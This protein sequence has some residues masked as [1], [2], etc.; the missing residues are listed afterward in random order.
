LALADEEGDRILTLLVSESSRRRFRF[1]GE[2]VERL[3]DGRHFRTLPDP[4]CLTPDEL[5]T[6][7]RSASPLAESRD[8][9]F[10]GCS[11]HQARRT[12]ANALDPRGIAALDV[13]GTAPASRGIALELVRLPFKSVSL[14][15]ELDD[16]PGAR[17]TTERS[18]ANDLALA[19]ERLDNAPEGASKKVRFD[20]V[21]PCGKK[22]DG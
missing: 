19:D 8:Q 11:S 18:V 3:P 12:P 15:G 1:S 13:D 21:A 20:V 5:G 14:V 17:T 10:V 6:G 2:H 22:E 9:L 7:E 16:A 4:E